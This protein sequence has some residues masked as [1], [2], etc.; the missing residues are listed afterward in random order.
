MVKNPQSRY[1]PIKKKKKRMADVEA[2]ERGCRPLVAHGGGTASRGQ[3]ARGSAQC[4]ILVEK[5][6]RSS[7]C[8]V[9]F[10]R[11]AQEQGAWGNRGWL[12]RVNAASVVFSGDT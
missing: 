9:P 6:L 4:I 5:C 12:S 10:V 8:Q 2:F 11:D 1:P 3:R 7:Q